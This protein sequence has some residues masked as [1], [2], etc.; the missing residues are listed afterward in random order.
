LTV[1]TFL[2]IRHAAVDGLG[3]TLL[4]RQ[5]GIHLNQDGK[6]QVDRLA[7]RLARVPAAAIYSSP[8]ERAQE[9]ARAIGARI[10]IGFQVNEALDEIDYGMWTGKSFRELNELTRWHEYNSH[11]SE[12]QIPGGESVSRFRRRA[13]EAL[14]RFCAV[15]NGNPVLL[16]THADWIRTAVADRLGLCLNSFIRAFEISP[17]SVCVLRV[18]QL[19]S[20]LVR[21]NDTGELESLW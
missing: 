8:L 21:W 13:C 3:V 17:A 18:E 6:N 20:V 5:A 16:V 9:T 15:H 19:G 14:T 12:A 7:D 4:G 11:R 1:T 2:M 10:G